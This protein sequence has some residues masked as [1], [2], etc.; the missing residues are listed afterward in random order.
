MQ[1]YKLNLILP[2]FSSFYL[3]VSLKC[4]NFVPKIIN[5]IK[6]SKHH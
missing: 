4:V 3:F 1:K 6:L 2:T 5:L